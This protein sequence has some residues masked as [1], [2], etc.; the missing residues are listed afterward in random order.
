MKNLYIVL[1]A[2]LAIAFTNCTSKTTEAVTDTVSDAVKEEMPSIHAWRANVPEPA[3]ARKI[4]LGSYNTFTLD[5]G[6]EVIVVENNKIP[7]VSYSVSLKNDP[8]MEGDQAGYVTMMGD[9]LGRG[10]T[11]K[12]KA[13]IDET[14]DFIGATLSTSAGGIFGRSLTKHSDKMLALMS[15]VL[16]NPTFPQ[17]EFD[18]VKS[19]MLSGLQSE[20]SDPNSMASNVSSVVNYTTGHPYGEVQTEATVENAQLESCKKYY[21]DF[22]KSNNAY[23][24]IV[25]DISLDDAKMKAEKYFG[26]WKSGDV[27]SMSYGM[28]KSPDAT[29]VSFVNKDGAVQS[30]INITYPVDLQPGTQEAIAASLT[31]SIL[32]GGIFLGRLM[33]NLREDNAFTYGARSRLSADDLVGNF[34]AFASVR[35]EVT[36]SSVVE[37][38]Y[39]MNRMMTEEVSEDDLQLAKNSATGSFA[40]SLESPQTIARFAKNIVKYNLPADYYETYLEKLESVTVADVKA[41]AE[42]FIRADKANI[43]IVGN[44]DEVAEKLVRFDADGKIDY[45]DAFGNVVVY[46]DKPMSADITGESIINKYFEALGGKAAM[47]KVKSISQSMKMDMMGQQATVKQMVKDRS[48]IAVKVEMQGMVVQDQRFDGEKVLMSGMGNNEVIT[49]G[50]MIN[51]MKEQTKIWEQVSYMDEGYAMEVKGKDKIDGED[52]YKLVVTNPE[53]NKST[54]FYSVDSGLL[55]KK[56][57]LDETSGKSIMVSFSEYTETDGIMFFGKMTTEGAMPFPMVMESTGVEVNPELSDDLFKV[58]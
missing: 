3:P 57:S 14:I 4:Q 54:E 6:L 22:F 2:I 35:N 8:I 42:K 1:F 21:N 27:P 30:V 24:T 9:L 40:R 48:K 44:K 31:N 19:Q 33:Q 39:E 15:D 10:T 32:G 49:E 43:V 55:L 34:N 13:E 7:K 51:Q 29:N 5:N 23:L 25:G 47:D 46:D 50:P 16:M 38:I 17:E 36:D 26:A 11:S 58:E 53:G 56:V 12:S 41:C 45:Y 20:K 52:V 37:F 18:K 28:P